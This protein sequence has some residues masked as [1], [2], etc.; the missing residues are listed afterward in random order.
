[1]H[2]ENKLLS[3]KM[4]IQQYVHSYNIWIQ[5]AESFVIEDDERMIEYIAKKT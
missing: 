2:S 1:M 4:E 3:S 5:K